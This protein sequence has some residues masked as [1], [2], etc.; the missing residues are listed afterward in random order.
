MQMAK[1]A[2]WAV[3]VLWPARAATLFAV[4]PDPNTFAPNQL[5]SVTTTP[6]AVTTIGTLGDGS[7][8][9]NGGLTAGPGGALYGVANDF[10]GASSLYTI[11]PNGATSLVGGLGFGFLGGLAYN[12]ATSAF[13]AAANDPLGNSAL[14]SITVSGG[15]V[16]AVDEVERV[17]TGFSGLA[18][19]AADGLIYGIGNDNTGF[20]TLYSF[21][22]ASN[23]SAVAGLGFGFGALSY[24]AA[25]GLFW[26]I[27]PVNNFS[28]QLFQVSA[29]G[30]VSA[31]ILTL[32]DGFAALAV[33]PPP[34][35]QTPEPVMQSALGA[36][37]LGMGIAFLRRRR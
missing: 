35:A 24:D 7:L 3:A 28:S 10:T 12:P 34:A 19:D 33:V 32:G 22:L 23:E 31:L 5:T 15:A 1:V 8:A 13:Y 11:Q 20:S 25:A 37:L 29:A 36:A 6:P 9:F 4:G 21:D 18:Y 14:Y 16:T 26:A 27:D 30:A 2:V 17:G